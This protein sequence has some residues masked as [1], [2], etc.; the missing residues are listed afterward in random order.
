MSA[1]DGSDACGGVQLGSVDV[2]VVQQVVQWIGVKWGPRPVEWW[3]ELWRDKKLEWQC[4]VDMEM[5]EGCQALETME[6][7]EEVKDIWVVEL[8]PAEVVWALAE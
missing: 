7:M 1:G 8:A 4:S 5:E 3:H 2:L 6:W